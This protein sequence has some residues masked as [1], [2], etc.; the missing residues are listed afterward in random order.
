MYHD[1]TMKI[2]HYIRFN[3]MYFFSTNK[4][5]QL[6]NLCHYPNAC[7]AL[8]RSIDNRTASLP[9]R[10][11]ATIASLNL[12]SGV[13]DGYSVSVGSACR[14]LNT[15]AGGGVRRDRHMGQL[16]LPLNLDCKRHSEWNL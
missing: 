10:L 1:E 7:R 8:F 4:L 3:L 13:S 14:E 2:E 12:F 11:E 9:L 16:Y 5:V 6:F 15:D